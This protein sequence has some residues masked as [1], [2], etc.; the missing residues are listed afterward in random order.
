MATLSGKNYVDQLL[1]QVS[2][3]YRPQG[4]ISDKILPIM[5]VKKAS[6]TIGS[7]DSGNMRIVTTLK[8]PMGGTPKVSINVSTAAAYQL[9]KHALAAPVSMDDI[10]NAEDPFD[11]LKDA[12]EYT[13]DLI[14]QASERGLS[15]FMNTSGNFTNKTTPTNKWSASSDDPVGDVRSAVRNAAKLA[16]KSQDQIS[17]IIGKEA[18]DK[19]IDCSEVLD[20]G[21]RYTRSSIIQ[22]VDIA[23][24]F[25][26]KEVIVGESQYI[27]TDEGQTDTWA[28]H[29]GKHCWAVYLPNGPETKQRCFGW[30][31]QRKGGIYVDRWYD[32]DLDGWFV[33]SNR[34]FDHYIQNEAICYMLYDVIS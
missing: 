28:Y 16:Q 21:F 23:K 25:G 12:A 33:R 26:I 3:G 4:L 22:P 9:E 13:T 31:C 11:P 14:M 24:M 1:T 5:T 6:G 10:D 2:I 27:S 17:V 30:T 18:W 15:S 8:A 29:W 32:N 7:Y 19:F 20:Y 34:E